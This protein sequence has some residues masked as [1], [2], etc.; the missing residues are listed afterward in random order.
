MK[1]FNSQEFLFDGKSEPYDITF[2]KD[3]NR[4]VII[5]PFE[6][7]FGGSLN[8]NFIGLNPNA[9]NS[10]TDFIL[11]H[12]GEI[13]KSLD[14]ITEDH[15]IAC[16]QI[17]RYQQ[18]WDANF[19]SSSPVCP[20]KDSYNIK[21]IDKAAQNQITIPPIP[22]RCSQNLNR[23]TYTWTRDFATDCHEN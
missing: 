15:F 10:Y 18:N 4:A 20:N 5:Q 6:F 2:L 17:F 22:G 16:G 1:M 23:A 21:V 14:K 12:K 13:Y 19:I 3:G 9:Y 7:P 11:Y 8:S